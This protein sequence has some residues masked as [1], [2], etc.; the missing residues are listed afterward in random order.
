MAPLGGR[1]PESATSQ[2]GV[3]GIAIFDDIK[4]DIAQAYNTTDPH[5]QKHAEEEEHSALAKARL[6]GLQGVV[7]LQSALAL[8]ARTE[9]LMRY[10]KEGFVSP[11]YALDPEE[12]AEALAGFKRFEETHLYRVEQNGA[13]QMNHAWLPW[14]RDLARHPAIVSAVCTIFHTRNVYLYNSNL[15]AR[16]PGRSQ[17][18]EMGVGWHTDASSSFS[19]LQPVDRRHFCTVFV[20]LTDCDREHGCLKVRPT[21]PGESGMCTLECDLP[22]KPGEFSLHGPSTPHTGGLN[23]SNEK[24][25]CVALRYIRASTRDEHV[26]TLG[27]DICLLVAGKDEK[28]NFEAMPEVPGEATEEGLKLRKTVLKKRGIGPTSYSVDGMVCA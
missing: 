25:Y 12:I 21:A 5:H 23:Q 19:R 18:T 9:C 2:R 14:L 26:D 11:L 24:R 20:A 6:G 8:R 13:F 7:Q 16:K 4:K 1:R 15:F 27:K 17:E 28:G 22:L 10:E 3:A